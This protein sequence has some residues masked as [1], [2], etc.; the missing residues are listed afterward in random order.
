MIFTPNLRPTPHDATPWAKGADRTC[1]ET[2]LNGLPTLRLEWWRSE[3][4]LVDS[5]DHVLPC[6]R[7]GLGRLGI[8]GFDVRGL[9]HYR[10]IALRDD[11]A[12]GHPVHLHRD[13]Q[14]PY[15]R[16]AIQVRSIRSAEHAG[17]VNKQK[18]ATLAKMLDSG[19]IL[20]AIC[21]RGAPAGTMPTKISI[22]VARP[23]LLAHLMRNV[24]IDGS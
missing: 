24:R 3:L 21:L 23:E 11:F 10:S 4:W 8:H 14:N 22:L 12:P 5:N 15:D 1:F 20:D 6:D 18:A 7:R 19:D 2:D 9:A 16:N 17:F 13:P